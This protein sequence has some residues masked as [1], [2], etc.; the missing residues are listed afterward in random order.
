MS[1]LCRQY[2]ISRKTGYQRV[3]RF[4]AEGRAGL[5]DRSH[6][7]HHQA[8]AVSQA[9][10]AAVLGVR[11]AHPYWGARKVRAW[12]Q[13]REPAQAW[14]AARRSGSCCSATA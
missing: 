8:H 9:R 4:V 1:Q 7:R 10:E 13:R 3:A 14:P 5:H 2:G 12:L 6:A 11:H